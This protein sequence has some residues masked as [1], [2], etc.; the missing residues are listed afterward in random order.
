MLRLLVLILA[1]VAALSACSTQEQPGR[2]QMAVVPAQPVND[3]Q[4]IILDTASGEG[5]LFIGKKV[6]SF[7]YEREEISPL[8]EVKRTEPQQ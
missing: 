6:Q 3:T 2:Y 5:K 8:R 7:S 4:L 1:S